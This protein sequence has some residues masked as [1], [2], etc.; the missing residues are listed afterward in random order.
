MKEKLCEERCFN[1]GGGAEATANK[2]MGQRNRT[3]QGAGPWG[4]QGAAP[5]A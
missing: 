5:F 1:M 2:A 4:L 3:V